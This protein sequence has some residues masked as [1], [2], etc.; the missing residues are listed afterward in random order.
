MRTRTKS[1]LRAAA[2]LAVIA[3]AAGCTGVPDGVIPPEDMARLMADVHTGEAF[4]DMNRGQYYT[5]S[6]KQTIRQSV[7]AKH[8]VTAEEV[9]SSFGWYG[10][11]IGKYMD[12]YTRTIEILEH[13]IIETG[14]RIA[15]ENA[16]S[17]AGDSVDVWPN[18]RFLTFNALQPSSIVTFSFTSDDNWEKGDTYTWRGKFFNNAGEARWSIMTEYTDGMVEFT[19][20]SIP[21]DGW[22]ELV[23]GTDSTRT[24]SRLYGYLASS[25]AEGTSMHVD[26]MTMVRKRMNPN[27][28]II[29]N[30][31]NRFANLAEKTDSLAKK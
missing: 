3:L 27:S 22:N 9:D 31:A 29:P 7:Y 17:I 28:Y 5:D 6:M 23:I 19:T 24:V 10:R 1:K 26:S 21:A 25:F 4:I 16:L 14:N 11:N 15:A 18:P 12:V 2:A 8:G 30:R 20:R 13:R